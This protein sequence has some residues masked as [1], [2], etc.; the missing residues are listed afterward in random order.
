MA[1]KNICLIGGAGFLGSSFR[2][3]SGSLYEKIVVLG[4]R[5]HLENLRSNEI[6]HSIVSLSSDK[7]AE[8]IRS[9]SV[10]AVI[11]LSYNTVPKSSFDNPIGDFSDNLY[12]TIHHLEIMRSLPGVRYVYVSSGGTVYGNST[13]AIP[14]AE[15]HS[16]IP[17]SPYG[18]TKFTSERYALMYKEIYGLDVIILRPSNVYGPG[19]MPY[20]GQGFVA[21]AMANALNNNPVQVF[22]DGS[23]IRD[24]LHVRDF[25]KALNGLLDHGENGGVYNIGLGKGYSINEIAQKIKEITGVEEFKI[26]YLPNRPF[27]VHYNV[28]SHKKISDLLNWQP[29]VSIEEGL[30]TSFEWIKGFLK[31][32]HVN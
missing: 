22:G 12:A 29:E 1:I 23:H 11:D 25:C 28:L 13:E 31:K 14:I 24:Y 3:I 8:I 17:L 2:E 6:Y 20:R 26:Q 9:E 32:E 5:P 16:N 30:A 18:I 15:D 10:E 21:T 7:V 27:D 4:R 19:Q